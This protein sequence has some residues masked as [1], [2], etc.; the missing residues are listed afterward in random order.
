MAASNAPAHPRV[1]RRRPQ[2]V[3]TLPIL[4]IVLFLGIV[5]LLPVAQLLRL[6]FLDAGGGLSLQ[7]YEKLFSTPL[8]IRVL[9]ITFKVALWTTLISLVT[10]YPVAYLLATT[11]ER[12]RAHL[13]LWIL[14]PFW[15]SFLVR[16]F[17]WIVLLGRKGVVNE[18]IQSTGLSDAPLDIIYNFIGVM[19]GMCHTLM[20]M[21]VLAM[22]SVMQNIDT[23][24]LKAA[25]TL[26]ARGGQAFWRV[27]FPLSMPG[28]AAAGLLVFI[29]ALGFFIIPA[30]LGGPRDMMIAQLIIFQVEELLNWGFG[31]ALGVLLL[32]TAIVVFFLYDRILGMSTLA[33]SGTM[34]D[35]SGAGAQSAV[36]RLSAGLGGWVIAAL[37]RLSDMVGAAADRLLPRRVDRPSRAD[38]RLAVRA[39]AGLLIVF[40]AVPS[41]FVIPVSFTEGEFIEWPPRG[42]SWKWYAQV[43]DSPLWQAAMFR[44]VTVGL[45]TAVLSMLIGVPAAFVLARRRLRAKSAIMALI[46]SPLIVPNIIIAVALFYLYARLGLVGTSLGLVIGHTV[47]AVPFVVV[48]VMAVLKSYDERLDQAAASLGANRAATLRLVTFP[49]IKAGMIAGFLFAFVKSFDELTVALFV[50]GG[51]ATTLPKQMWADAALKVNPSLAAVSTIMLL[52]VTGAILAAEHLSRRS[53]R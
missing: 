38:S 7:H 1:Y 16:T 4:P 52:V 26:G 15:T 53:A 41:F 48:T 31:G 20:P 18:L 14:M 37:G 40:L 21:A 28:V 19:I 45:L 30:L 24:L 50:T 49:L 12:S 29:T 23:N 5:F 46:L 42:F 47:L 51:L 17:A 34:A 10:S 27:Y 25:S 2:W 22:L 35:R 33:G 11:S 44:S 3:Q 32:M 8:Y 13:L 36:A 9:S 6:S 43:I 39:I